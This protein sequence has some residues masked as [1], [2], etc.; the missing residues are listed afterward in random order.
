MTKFF[1]AC[2]ILQFGG[3]VLADC[4]NRVTVAYGFYKN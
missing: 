1:G 4:E 3:F 2:A